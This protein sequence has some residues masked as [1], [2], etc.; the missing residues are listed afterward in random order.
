MDAQWVE[1]RSCSFLHEA[2]FLMS[3]LDAAGIESQI[4]DEYAL[5]VQPGI[6]AFGN[7]RL[8][9]RAEDLE[10]ATEVLN[11]PAEQQEAE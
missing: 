3:V 1:V 10:R 8:L 11:S 2:E 9:V 7:V 6:A 5:G 4:P